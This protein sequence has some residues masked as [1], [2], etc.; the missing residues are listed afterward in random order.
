MAKKR[1]KRKKKTRRRPA[2]PIS[3][4][5]LKRLALVYET[6]VEASAEVD[7][8]LTAAAKR[9]PSLAAAWKRGRFLANLR[10]LAGVVETVSEAARKL[11]LPNGQA[12]REMIDTDQEIA[13]IW[14]QTRL[15]TRLEVR[16]AVLEQAR[17]G[18]QWAI[19]AVEMYLRDD[20][21]SPSGADLRRMQQKQ[22]AEL[23]GVTRVTV[24]EWTDKHGC[25]RN[26][27][28]S[29]PLADVLAWWQSYIKAK[30]TSPADRPDTLRNL[31]A[32]EK[33]LDIAARRRELLDRD[34]VLAGLLAR[35]QILLGWIR[36]RP[37]DLGRLCQGQKPDR[38]AE[39]IAGSFD[40]LRRQLCTVPAE[41]QLNPEAATLFE[42]TLAAL[43]DY[44]GGGV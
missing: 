4:V 14:N 9:H 1:T 20:Q 7:L 35:H 11:D 32:E 25:P 16:R 24:K 17:D 3:A 33:A 27:D 6:L 5:K 44:K 26:I 29:Y 34:E 2:W 39:I 18:N 36:Q 8:D 21:P 28:G 42:Q 22:I 41:L 12:L 23:F 37:G 19:R 31:K 40:E 30:Y 15:N 13:E 43:H 38:I 10:Q